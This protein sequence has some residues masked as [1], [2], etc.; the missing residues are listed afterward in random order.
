[1]DKIFEIVAGYLEVKQSVQKRTAVYF[2]HGNIARGIANACFIIAFL[3]IIYSQIT[4]IG[5]NNYEI[6]KMVPASYCRGSA[7]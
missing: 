1:M 2:R 3:I 7:G 6:K 4:S 5:I